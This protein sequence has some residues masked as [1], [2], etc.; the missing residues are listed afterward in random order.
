MVIRP[1]VNASILASFSK[2]EIDIEKYLCIKKFGK[3]FQNSKQS[4]WA[5]LKLSSNWWLPIPQKPKFYFSAHKENYF[6]EVEV[7]VTFSTHRKS[8]KKRKHFWPKNP[9]GFVHEGGKSACEILILFVKIDLQKCLN[10]GIGFNW[11]YSPMDGSFE[12]VLVSVKINILLRKISPCV[13]R[14]T[15]ILKPQENNLYFI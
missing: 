1:C 11:V 5:H 3:S 8:N 13:C 6:K 10:V 15:V 7:G 2:I 12:Q 14:K 4:V 9:K